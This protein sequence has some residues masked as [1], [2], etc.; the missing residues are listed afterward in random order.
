MI[1]KTKDDIL[2]RIKKVNGCWEW[3]GRNNGVNY[4]QFSEGRKNI[5]AHRRSYEIFKGPIPT[6]LQLDHLCRNRICVNPSHLEAVTGKVNILRGTAPSAFHAKATHC[7]YGHPYA[8]DNLKLT[9]KK[10]SNTYW[11][12]CHTC[13]RA[14]M[15][16]YLPAWKKRQKLKTSTVHPL[17]GK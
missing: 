3:Q 9:Y 14:Y 13:L 17:L 4:G 16:V 8:G 15:K 11:R 2:S 5:R 10:K 6:G 7:P 1:V 12:G